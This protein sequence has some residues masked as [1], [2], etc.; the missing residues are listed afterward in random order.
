MSPR[1]GRPKADNPKATQV[2]AR[3]DKA[4]IEKLEENAAHYNE[5][6]ADSIRRGI[7]MVNKTIK[8]SRVFLS[9]AR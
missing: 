5:S 2:S 9:A 7:E 8:N 1:T 3:L 4:T 6:K